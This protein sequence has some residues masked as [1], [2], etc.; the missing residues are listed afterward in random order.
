MVGSTVKLNAGTGQGITLMR[1]TLV[2]HSTRM[3]QV[4]SPLFLT[5]LVSPSWE[6]VSGLHLAHQVS[7]VACRVVVARIPIGIGTGIFHPRPGL[8]T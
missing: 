8:L 3:D 5:V 1:N 2:G 6:A 4:A 7:T